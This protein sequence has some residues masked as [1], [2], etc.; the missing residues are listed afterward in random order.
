MVFFGICF[1]FAKQIPG[2]RKAKPS[3]MVVVVAGG[4]RFRFPSLD[5]RCPLRVDRALGSSGVLDGR[6]DG[7]VGFSLGKWG[8]SGVGYNRCVFFCL[9]GLILLFMF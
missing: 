9:V 7:K 8:E 3:E 6:G 5:D 2:F 1:F 4:G